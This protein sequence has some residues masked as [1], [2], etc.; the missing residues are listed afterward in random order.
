[1]SILL[2]LVEQ[3]YDIVRQRAARFPSAVALGAQDGLGWRTLDSRALLAHVDGVAAELTNRGVR[4]GDRVV[5]WAPSGLR[6]P[7][8]LF[9]LWRLG[10]IAV[11]F[12]RDMNPSAVQ[13]IL[14]SVE[15]R[16]VIVG[17]EH[18]PPWARD[19]GAVE[20][21]EPVPLTT[22]TAWQPPA[23]ELAAIFFTSGTT[24]QPKGCMISHANL[25]SQVAAF[26]RRIPLDEHCRLGSILP[27]S[28]LFELTC[29][30]LYPLSR[31]AAIHYIP[32]RRGADVVRVLAEQ[33]V[34]HMMAVPQLLSLMGNA[35]EQ[36]LRSRLPGLAY[37]A[38]IGLAERV[39]IPIR[40]RLFFMVHRQI[41]G[42]L[43]L[44]AAGGAALPL[45]T[46][47]LW[48]LL[49]VDIIQ[50]YGTSECSPVI[51][52]GEPRRTPP[53][54]VGPPLPGVQVRLSAEGELQ[55]RGPN[56]MRGY[57]RD[58]QRTAEVLSD[59][60]WYSTGDLARIDE[61]GSIWLQGRA[62]D[63]IVLPNGMNVWPQDVEDALR[64]QP[65]VQDAAVLAVPTAGGGARL[66]GYLIPAQPG[67][68]ARDPQQ[69]LARA[70]ARLA[71]H[72]R[73]ASASWWPDTDFPR[74][75]TLKVRRHLLPRPT[76]D[77]ARPLAPPPID[78]DPVVEA[79][80]A[81]ARVSTVGDDQTLAELGIDSLGIVELVVQLED[82]TGR[83]LEEGA[84]STEMRVT[85]LRAA[86]ASAPLAE[87]RTAAD[88]ETAQPLPVPR[89]FYAHGSLA[90][91]VLT[92]PFDL[93]YRAAIPRTIVLGAEHLA[94]LRRGVVFAGN[95]RSFADM[96]LIRVGLARTP[97]RRFSR[98]LVVAALAEGE[99]WRSP[100]ARYAAAAFGLYPLDRTSQ[101]EASLRRLAD[102]ARQGNA[103]LIFPQGTHARP[104]EERGQPPA[105]RFKTGVAHVAEALEAPVVP[106]GLAGTELAMPPFLDDF[107][108][109]KVAGVPVALRRTTLAIAFGPPQLREVGETAQQFTERLE[110]LSYALAAQ[111]DKARTD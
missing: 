61:H 58:P 28:H 19:S 107:K 62:R 63:L 14:R 74:T 22:Q 82:R 99:G 65:D 71:S 54:S 27:L 89:W 26:P 45:E 55:A 52:C 3:L 103:V 56:V 68:R 33:R 110:R 20:W 108:G 88:I 67:D 78:G 86:V 95:H 7:V 105:V 46:Q 23:E 30:L 39:S 53:G 77:A 48:E 18:Q 101:R 42:R 111:A 31:G 1:M 70:N 36:R 94:G 5:L 104:S 38:L 80:A 8:Y 40:R 35:L 106:F 13:A 9:A 17:Y 44:M 11:P 93:L 81:V 64:A 59:D 75:S 79:V 12:D 37:R 60:G 21:W 91:P 6:T 84:L 10:A 73:V 57:W 72:Q 92:L 43:R 2:R 109:L 90:R 24:G 49:G 76:D 32:S 69:L 34:T 97:A 25:C 50:G 15:P 51:A 102:L 41:G 4:S 16:L 98:R 96:P 29:G 83:A 87:E 100:L 85:A 66:H 47:H